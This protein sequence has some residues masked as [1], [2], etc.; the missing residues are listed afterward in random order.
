MKQSSVLLYAESPIIL[1]LTCNNK[2]KKKQ[3]ALKR[4]M[5]LKYT[6]QEYNKQVIDPRGQDQWECK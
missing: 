1:D 6:W 4:G 5:Q 3:K 2:L